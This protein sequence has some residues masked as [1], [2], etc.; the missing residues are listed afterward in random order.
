MTKRPENRYD[1]Y[2]AHVYF[3]DDSMEWAAALCWGAGEKFDVV[4]GRVHCKLVGPHPRW[5]CQL[6]FDSGQFDG[7]IP[8]LEEWREGLA[9]LVYGVTGDDLADHTDHAAWLGEAVPLNLNMFR[10]KS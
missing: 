8:W 7:V 5:C 4:V 10:K 1:R 2:H 6:A 9:G 3:D